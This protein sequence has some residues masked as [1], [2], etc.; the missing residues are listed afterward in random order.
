METDDPL[1]LTGA[2]SNN[3]SQFASMWAIREGLTEAVGKEGK[4]YKYDISIPVSSFE[5]V[6]KMTR[7]RCDDLGLV[8]D[9]L[10]KDVVGYGHIGDG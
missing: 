4:A 3:E 5:D 6:I 10:V 8:K 7:K 1:I 9:G 2:L